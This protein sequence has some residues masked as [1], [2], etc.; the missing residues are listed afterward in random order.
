MNNT[1]LESKLKA[2]FQFG[3]RLPDGVDTPSLE[4]AKSAGW[5]SIGHLQLIAAIEKEFDIMISTRD[6]L[7]MN[8]YKEAV[9]IVKKYVHD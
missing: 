6:V 8:S 7:S 9:N 5:D 4:F 1:P 3:L 2:A